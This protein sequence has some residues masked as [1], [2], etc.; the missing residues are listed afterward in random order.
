MLR[1]LLQEELQSQFTPPTPPH[2][3]LRLVK[4]LQSLQEISRGPRP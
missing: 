4:S 2:T 3:P 1:Y